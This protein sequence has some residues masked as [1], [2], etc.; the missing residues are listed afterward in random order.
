MQPQGLSAPVRATSGEVAQIRAQLGLTQL[1]LAAR[2]GVTDVTVSR[3]E[4][5][6]R[7]PTRSHTLALR[8]LVEGMK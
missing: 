6:T 2:L 3:W 7:T 5:A 4:S 1:Q 8:R